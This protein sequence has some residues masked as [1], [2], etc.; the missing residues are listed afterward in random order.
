MV[1]CRVDRIAA[2]VNMALGGSPRCATHQIVGSSL[3]FALRALV[4]FFFQYRRGYF[5]C[6]ALATTGIVAP[7]EVLDA[8]AVTINHKVEAGSRGTIA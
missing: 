5:C 2:G 6:R 8:H 4:T 3:V 7:A 1:D